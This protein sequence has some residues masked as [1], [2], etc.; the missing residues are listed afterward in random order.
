MQRLFVCV[1]VVVLVVAGLPPSSSA[2]Q[3][4]DDS[5]F[6]PEVIAWLHANAVPLDSAEPGSGYEDLLPLQDMIGD[7]RIVALGEATHTTREFF[8]MKHRLV[9]FLVQEMGFT[10]FALEA[11]W[12]EAERLNHYVLTGEGDPVEALAYL[13][14]F[15]TVEM[16]D[17]VLWMRDYNA[18]RGDAPPVQFTGF[19]AQAGNLAAQTVIAYV[20]TVDP[21]T[22][23]VVEQQLGCVLVFDRD[24]MAT[25]EC[26][27]STQ[28]VLSLLETNA[29]EYTAL[30]SPEEYEIAL[31]HAEIAAQSAVIAPENRYERDRFMADNVTW[32][33]DHAAPNAKIILSAHNYHVGRS[34]YVMGTRLAERYGDDYLPVG[35]ALYGGTYGL[36]G[37]LG[38]YRVLD[39]PALGS[40]SLAAFFQTTGYPFLA[41]DL[42]TAQADRGVWQWLLRPHPVI[43]FGDELAA[44]ITISLGANFDLVVYIE[45]TTAARPL[46]WE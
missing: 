10:V 21:E 41:V 11:G 46:F 29:E 30:T 22:V 15:N 38:G 1:F 7:A 5:A 25:P 23:P 13:G 36:F 43:Q 24:R 35:F 32:L 31:H 14:I 45:Q 6:D 19:D 28:V 18:T 2:A 16:L 8:T 27:E 40:D 39:L 12:P 20:E 17:L 37:G 42:R 44:S 26:R 3:G 4:Q 9:E 33:L 34:G